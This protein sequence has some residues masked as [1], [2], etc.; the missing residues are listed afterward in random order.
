MTAPEAASWLSNPTEQKHQ[1]TPAQLLLALGQ[2][3]QA[4]DELRFAAADKEL[5]EKA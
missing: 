4:E 3:M 2:R 5:K 1:R